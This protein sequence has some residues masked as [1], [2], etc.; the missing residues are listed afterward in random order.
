M[1]N[2]RVPSFVIRIIGNFYGKSSGL[3]YWKCVFSNEFKINSGT[4]QGGILS[5]VLYNLYIIDLIFSL[6]NSGYGCEIG[7]EYCGVINYADDIVRI[8][9]SLVKMQFM[10]DICYNYGCQHIGYNGT[11]SQFMCFGSECDKKIAESLL[12]TGML[13]S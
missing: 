9:G 8:S 7:S 1:I 12:G 13:Q 11:K 6:R 4:R 2:T 5:A 3:V 10:L